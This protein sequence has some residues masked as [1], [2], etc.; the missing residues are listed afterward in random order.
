M[1]P[2]MKKLYNVT[3]VTVFFISMSLLTGSIFPELQQ[4]F[5][6][7]AG[8]SL[9]SAQGKYHKVGEISLG[10][11]PAYDMKQMGPPYGKVIFSPDGQYL[12]T[13]TEKGEVFLF[14]SQG[15]LLWSKRIGLGKIS[16]LSFTNDGHNLLI[17]ETSPCG[18]LSSVDAK[19][20][21]ER[22]HVDSINELGSDI[23][24]K[25]YPGIVFITADKIGNLYAVAQRYKLNTIG[26]R[27]YMS[28]I[29]KINAQDG[30]VTQFPAEGNIDAW[31]GGVSVDDQGSRVLFGAANFYPLE[32]ITYGD[33]FYCLDGSLQRVLWSEKL[34]TIE[35]FQVVTVRNSPCI[36]GDGSV[37]A[38]L[39]SDGR[40]YLYTADGAGLWERIISKPQK[41]AGIYL[42]PAGI[43]AQI[44]GERVLFST[45]NTY[46]RANW[47]LPAPVDH[48]SSNSLFM[49]DLSGSL[50]RHYNAGGMI[51]N[52]AVSDQHIALSVG[53]NVR[54]GN[55]NVHGIALLAMQ[56]GVL[57][58]RMSMTGPCISVDIS[59]DGKYVAGVET[60]VKVDSGEILGGYRLHIWQKNE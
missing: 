58:D 6:K 57:V 17:G 18:A 45:S 51:G 41:I 2:I 50:V 44:V 22:W 55:I 7:P 30:A 19:T 20:G 28:R 11:A 53:S 10:E 24:Q 27:E 8:Q 31:V 23:Q 38:A 34:Q 9:Q 56:D 21:Q 54:T 13:G 40:S 60:P 16:A 15:K 36:S 12:A 39:A 14:S 35:P 46:N 3:L 37:L 47:K 1:K 32:H 25:I 5:E 43:Y 33:H 42:N 48:P 49:F 52:I 29:Y 4:Y 59:Q 26:N